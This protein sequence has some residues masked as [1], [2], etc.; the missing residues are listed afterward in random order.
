MTVRIGTSNGIKKRTKKIRSAERTEM[1]RLAQ[2]RAATGSDKD[3]L[4][5]AEVAIRCWQL[6]YYRAFGASASAVYGV[7]RSQQS[8]SPQKT[9]LDQKG[10]RWPRK[11]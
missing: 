4:S 6:K 1:E 2:Q 7:A 3:D 5:A 10:S 11:I 8:R 9:G